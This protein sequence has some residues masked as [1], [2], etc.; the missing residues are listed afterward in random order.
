[1]AEKMKITKSYK[2]GA[3]ESI[4]VELEIDIDK[5]ALPMANRAIFAKS[6]K[7]TAL[8]GGIK[9]RVVERGGQPVAA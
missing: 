6:G 1:M 7:A 3:G 2:N 5:L 9:C 4:K 8:E